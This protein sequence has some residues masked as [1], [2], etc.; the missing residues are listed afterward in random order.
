MQ[1]FRHH[2]IYQQQQQVLQSQ[3]TLAALLSVGGEEESEEVEADVVIP[4]KDLDDVLMKDVGDKIAT[5][6]RSVCV[7]LMLCHPS[8][9]YHICG[10]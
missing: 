4:I 1:C 7:C 9:T 5:S 6:G 3:H 8:G 10:W 2:A